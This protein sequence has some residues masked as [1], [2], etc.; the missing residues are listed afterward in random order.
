MQLEQMC[1]FTILNFKRTI[2]Q[3]GNRQLRTQ[4][5]L[6]YKKFKNS[7]KTIDQFFGCRIV[8][9]MKQRTD[10]YTVKTKKIDTK[11]LIIFG[12]SKKPDEFYFGK[13]YQNLKSFEPIAVEINVLTKLLGKPQINNLEDEYLNKINIFHLKDVQDRHAQTRTVGY[14]TRLVPAGVNGSINIG[15]YDWP[16]T[17]VYWLPSD[18]LISNSF[19]CTKTKNCYYTTNRLPNLKRHEKGCT[20][21]QEIISKQMEY[22][23]KNDEVSKLSEIMDIDLSEFRQ[24]H[25]VCF[26]IETFGKAEV[27]IPV[28]I[29]VASTLDGP[30]YFEKADD[31]LEA[32][33]Q[34]VKEFMDYL[35]K[36]QEK[37]VNNLEPEIEK[38]IS[39]LQADK[40]DF[41]NPQRYKSKA[42]LN[43]L[44]G[45]LKNYEVLKVFGFNSRYVSYCIIVHFE[46]FWT[47]WT[48]VHF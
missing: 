38:T 23:C 21:V 26:D 43:K 34:M 27:C 2:Y 16:T 45:Y 44:Y 7:K 30:K 46:H 5:E 14:I 25:H 20:D 24:K 48:I 12:D 35:L 18:N 1:I 36:L 42:E 37:L 8:K 10:E 6:A 17:D 9:A 32:G 13:D 31:T 11:T 41:F 28:S 22:G 39:F 19:M 40:E 3:V 4:I 47:F 15:V 29:A 33:Y